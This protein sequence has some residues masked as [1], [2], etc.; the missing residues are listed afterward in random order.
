[1]YLTKYACSTSCLARLCCLIVGG[2]PAC[3]LYGARV[4]TLPY[5][6]RFF[7]SAIVGMSSKVFPFKSLPFFDFGRRIPSAPQQPHCLKKKATPASSHWCLILC[8]HSGFIGRALVPD[9]PPTIT[10]WISV[11]LTRPKSS[12]NGSTER[13]LTLAPIVRR[14]SIR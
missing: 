8:T 7:Y 4:T 5:L 3:Q 9:S 14:T 12:S 1:M 6:N 10:Q 2:S 11:R 13:N